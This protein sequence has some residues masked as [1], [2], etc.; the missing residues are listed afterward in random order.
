LAALRSKPP[1][2]TGWSA[3]LTGWAKS[4]GG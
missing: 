1:A 4:F 3:R 2:P